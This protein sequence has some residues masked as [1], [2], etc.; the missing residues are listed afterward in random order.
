MRIA[1]APQA[2]IAIMQ[3]TS[4]IDP[5]ENAAT[6]RGAALQAAELGAVMLFAPEMAGLI[7]RDR[8][9]AAKHIDAEKDSPFVVAAAQAARDAGVWVHLGS[10]PVLD[11]AEGKWRNRSLVIDSAGHIAARYDKIHL[12]DIDLPNGTSWR[13]SA[14][15]APG[16]EAVVANTPLGLMG[17]AIC[18]DLRFDAL[19]DA[20]ALA[21]ARVIVVPSAFTVPTGQAHWHTLLRA[22][23][24]DHGCFVIAAAQCGTHADGRQ[25]YGHSLVV[26]PW[27]TILF[28]AGEENGV[29]MV[30]IDLEQIDEVR[31]RLPILQHRRPFASPKTV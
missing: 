22:R 29:S 1:P 11:E 24:I 3:M 30:D 12:F 8:V 26:D 18:Y 13:E 4:G 5:L 20:L 25:T 7:D 27:G 17:L 14:A 9:R 31:A 19:F 10:L 15:Y 2:R 23:A 28:D 6:L 21:G 16:A